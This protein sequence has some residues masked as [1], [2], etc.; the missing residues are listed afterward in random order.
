MCSL[1]FSLFFRV[2]VCCTGSHLCMALCISSTIVSLPHLSHSFNYSSFYI[3]LLHLELPFE[4]FLNKSNVRKETD[5]FSFLR[6]GCRCMPARVW[7]RINRMVFFTF[8][9]LTEEQQQKRNQNKKMTKSRLWIDADDVNFLVSWSSFFPTSFCFFRMHILRCVAKTGSVSAVD[10][11][12]SFRE[13][14]DYGHEGSREEKSMAEPNK[15]NGC[16]LTILP[17]WF[18]VHLC[19]FG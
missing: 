6:C 19:W 5:D 8:F 11:I 14:R 3:N 13:Q 1:I 15:S 4:F 2:H 18:C 12:H 10:Y 16:G 9:L 7:N 17:F